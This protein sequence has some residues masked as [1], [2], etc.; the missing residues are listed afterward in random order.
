[1]I[2]TSNFPFAK[3]LCALSMEIFAFLSLYT[4]NKKRT[5]N[6]VN[7]E[8]MPCFDMIKATALG[9]RERGGIKNEFVEESI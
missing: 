7:M 9:K 8:H 3:H 5:W 6:I 2:K 1:M 4:V